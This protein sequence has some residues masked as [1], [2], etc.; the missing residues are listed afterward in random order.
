[1]A[2]VGDV[3]AIPSSARH[4]F[5]TLYDGRRYA[6]FAFGDSAV[7]EHAIVRE[8]NKVTPFFFFIVKVPVPPGIQSRSKGRSHH[9]NELKGSCHEPRYICCSTWQS[10][11]PN[12]VRGAV[13]GRL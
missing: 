5:Y 9:D 13:G 12:G 8:C 3:L 7:L 1:M 10:P 6:T 2:Y 4:S 11:G